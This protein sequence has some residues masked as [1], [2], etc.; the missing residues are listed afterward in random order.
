MNNNVSKILG[1]IFMLMSGLFY[2]TERIVAKIAAAIVAAGYASTGTGTDSSARYPEFF[3]NF[4]V[5]FF[6][7]IGF[8]LLVY[9]F[10]KISE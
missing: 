2:T 10:R 9:G 1:T 3:E 5:W 4:F 7:L 8:V 6:L